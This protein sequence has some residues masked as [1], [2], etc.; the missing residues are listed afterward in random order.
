[1]LASAAT[2]L[3]QT[4]G[5]GASFPRIAYQTW[6][7]DS[8]AIC[9][10]T[11]V[12][13]TAGINDF[14]NGV[15]DFGGSDAPLTAAQLAALGQK[16]GGSGV[17]YFPTLLGAI[18][19]PTNIPGQPGAIQLRAQT[20]GKIF[21]GVI[22]NWNDPR[23]KADNVTNPRVKGF[24]FPSLPIAACVRQDGSGT[25]YAFTT[26]MAH[27]STDFRAKVA[28]SQLPAWTA[29]TIVRG[30]G[31]AGVANCVKTTSGSIGYVD[32]GDA[33]SAG[34]MGQLAYIGKS[35]LVKVKKRVKGKIRKV[36]VRKDI[37]VRPTVTTMKRAGDVPAKSI[38][39]NL[40][41]DLTMSKVSSAYPI[42]TTTYLL[43]YDD[44]G[45]AGKSGSL[46]GVKNVLNYFYSDAAQAKLPLLGFAPLP[47]PLLTAAKAQMAKLK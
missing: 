4:R 25:S 14:S 19:V 17:L 28:V 26:F 18:T 30:Q 13:S 5:S 7:Q 8:G 11:S 15:T 44:F 36:T 2:A 40:V 9:Q 32:L 16:R 41:L 47:A 35:E 46:A 23:I 27:A 20:V 1:M 33:G 21:A 43:A 24:T 10:Y 37:Y 39:G 45:K 6:C 22:T 3:G 42:V 31:N 29:P 34:L 12:G 38:P